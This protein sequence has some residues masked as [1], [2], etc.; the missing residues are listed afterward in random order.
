[1]PRICS[2]FGIVISMYW[3]EGAHQ[4]PHFHARYRDDEASV[5]FD[6]T[7][8]EG[9]LPA[10]SA[11][12]VREWTLLHQGELERNWELARSRQPLDAIDPLA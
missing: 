1:M 4:L 8:I 5:A 11:R 3:N 9:S 6:G 2:F 12:L 10:R 7:L